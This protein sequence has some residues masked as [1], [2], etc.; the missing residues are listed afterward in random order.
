M[1]NTEIQITVP[2]SCAETIMDVLDFLISV[3]GMGISYR[4]ARGDRTCFVVDGDV[5]DL[6]RVVFGLECLPIR[7][8]IRFKNCFVRV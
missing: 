3:Y 5:A 7:D 2:P 6:Q 8:Q 1:T 4:L